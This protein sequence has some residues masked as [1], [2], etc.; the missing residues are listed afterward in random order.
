M[1]H[2]GESTPSVKTPEGAACV[3][4]PSVWCLLGYT[5]IRPMQGQAFLPR[6]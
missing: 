1:H 6:P 3:N 2:L 5:H 4:P